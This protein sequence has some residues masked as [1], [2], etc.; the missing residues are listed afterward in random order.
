MPQIKAASAEKG[1][2]SKGVRN[3]PKFQT[4]LIAYS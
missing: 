3:K 1:R 4:M 2:S